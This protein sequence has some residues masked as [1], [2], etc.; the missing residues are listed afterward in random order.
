MAKKSVD[1]EAPDTFLQVATH[2]WNWVLAHKLLVAAVAFVVVV[3]A[4]GISGWA[5]YSNKYEKDSG[6]AFAKA[7]RYYHSLKPQSSQDDVN[8]VSRLLDDVISRYPR[9]KW[10][11]FA[12]LYLA[13][14]Y[15]RVGN[16]DGATR[17]YELGVKGLQEEKFLY[18]QWLVTSAYAQ[19]SPE[20]GIKVVKQGL[21]VEHPFLEPYLRYNLALL[22]QEKGDLEKA[23]KELQDLKGRF[24]S[25]PFGIEADKLL[26][27]FR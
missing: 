19:S 4:V 17:E 1:A 11:S 18:P 26:E 15:E 7:L 27:L 3:V 6:L 14:C 2:S 22:Y 8:S 25:S 12:H 21:Q 10:A 5:Y 23:K 9:S 24:S 20:E 16:S 13:R